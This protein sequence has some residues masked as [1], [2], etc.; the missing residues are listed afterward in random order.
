M[1]ETGIYWS[2]DWQSDTLIAPEGRLYEMRD[3]RSWGDMLIRLDAMQNAIEAADL[4]LAYQGNRR[5]GEM[6]DNLREALA[7]L[8][9]GK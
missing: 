9:A 4:L 8:E 3:L 1:S 6:W 7:K 5:E 2:G